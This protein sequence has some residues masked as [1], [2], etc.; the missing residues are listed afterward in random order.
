MT[1]T[2]APEARGA[3]RRARTDERLASTVAGQV[4]EHGYARLTIEKVAAA[5]GVAKTTIYRR[6]A[7]KAEMVFDL[8]VHRADQAPPINTGTLAGDVKALAE[9]AVALVTGDPGRDVLPGLLAD[10]AGDAQLAARLREAFVSAARDDITAILDRALD[11]GELTGEADADGFHAALLGIP[12]AH[13]HLLADDGA[14]R[15]SERLADQLL[16][17]LPLRH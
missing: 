16:R 15:L 2:Q 8:V 6:W 10:M 7:S 13:V 1:N 3:A 14:G 5:S 4:R 9:R 11:R 17:L 12:Y